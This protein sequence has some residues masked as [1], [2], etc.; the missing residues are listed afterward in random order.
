[1]QKVYVTRIYII[2]QFVINNDTDDNMVD[3][4]MATFIG[5]TSNSVFKNHKTIT[6]LYVIFHKICLSFFQLRKK[7]ENRVK[8]NQKTVI[9]GKFYI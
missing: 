7:S 9:C 3:A 8:P 5:H 2:L 6:L 4:V 1:M